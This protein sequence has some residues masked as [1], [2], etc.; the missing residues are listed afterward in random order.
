MKSLDEI[1]NTP[2]VQIIR[3]AEDGVSAFVNPAVS[4]GANL[5]VIA[6]CGG[7][8]DHVSVS[9]PNRCPTWAEMA[10]VKDMFFKP[11]EMAVEYHPA[12]SDYVNLHPFCLHIWRSQ[13]ETMPKPPKIYV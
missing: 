8:W 10:A 12:E 7:G 13:T 9:L 5:R 1:R 4:K 11:D 6:S 2:R 3:T